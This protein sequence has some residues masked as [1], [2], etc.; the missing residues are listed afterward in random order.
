VSEGR[1]FLEA[2]SGRTDSNNSDRLG[3][4]GPDRSGANAGHRRGG[5]A[6]GMG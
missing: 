2:H 4:L 1:N 3:W 6:P 5:W